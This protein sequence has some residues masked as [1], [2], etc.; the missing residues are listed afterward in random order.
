MANEQTINISGKATLDTT[1]A[2]NKLNSL[3]QQAQGLQSQLQ[4]GLAPRS[5]VVDRQLEYQNGRYS[6][7]QQ[8]KPQDQKTDQEKL[9]DRMAQDIRRE[10]L[11]RGALF[12]PGSSNFNQLMN[13]V[14]SQ[15]RANYHGKIEEKFGAA[16]TDTQRQFREEKKSQIDK[17]AQE[18]ANK[19]STA[20]SSR[21]R[22]RINKRYDSRVRSVIEGLNSRRDE[23]LSQISSTKNEQ[24]A[25]IEQ[26]LVRIATDLVQELR[27]KNPNSY[28]GNLRAEYQDA[29][30]RRENAETLEDAQA[31]SLEANEIQKRMSKAMGV[32]NPIAQAAAIWGGVNSGLNVANTAISA[33]FRNTASEIGEVNSA[34]NGDAFGAMQQDIERRRTNSSAWGAGIGALVGAIGGGIAAAFGSFGIGTAAGVGGGAALGTAAGTG[35][36]NAIFNWTHGAEENQIKLGQMWQQQE[37]RFQQFNELAL[38]THGINRNGLEAERQQWLN[39]LQGGVIG[40]YTTDNPSGVTFN[41]LG[42]TGAQFSQI[43]AQRIKQRGFIGDTVVGTLNGEGR[44]SAEQDI[45]RAVNQIALERAYNMSEGSLAQ[46]SVYDR[47]SKGRIKNDAN[48]DMANLVAS[49]SNMGTLGMS[50]G[51]TLRA[52][53]FLG[54]QTQLMELQK[55]WMDAP[56]SQFATQMLLAGQSL[57]GNNFDSR[58]INEMSQI[59]GTVT[60]PKEDY[61]KAILYDVIQ[62]EI[63]GT[64]GNLLAIRQAQYSDDPAVRNKIQS[65]MFKRLTEIYGGVDTTSGYLALSHYTGIQDPERLKKWVGQ[66]QKGLPAV[67]QGSVSADAAALKEYTPETSKKMLEYQDS[68]SKMIADNLA[69]LKGVS[70]QMLSTFKKQLDDIIT[71]LK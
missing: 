13:A 5:G 52:N 1:D 24:K 26:D 63:S 38:I 22:E 34:A 69:D 4:G 30:A 27:R 48:Q 43:A 68:T 8:E 56:S 60:N 47:Y 59:Q 21:Q 14:V 62:N 54:Y 20:T 9:N 50:G 57:F 15:Q 36:A 65:A 40:A 16:E 6:W 12:V 10:I 41:D 35:I 49:L 67:S 11:S 7:S 42:Y 66:M 33:Y 17:L 39:A 25:A 44:Y 29:I 31:A 19:L 3:S 70:D 61:S 53:E 28:L 23:A 2:E 37:Q 58:A 55:G 46:Y 64:K 45:Y 51:Q 71:E 32:R 18:R